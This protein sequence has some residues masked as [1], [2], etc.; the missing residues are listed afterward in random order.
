MPVATGPLLV[1]VAG[2]WCGERPTACAEL[3]FEMFEDRARRPSPVL[4]KW[5]VNRVDCRPYISDHGSPKSM[6]IRAPGPDLRLEGPFGAGTDA[7]GRLHSQNASFSFRCATAFGG[8]GRRCRS[9]EPKAAPEPPAAVG[10]SRRA[11]DQDRRRRK[12]TD[13]AFCQY[14]LTERTKFGEKW[15]AFRS[16]LSSHKA[17]HRKHRAAGHRSSSAGCE[18]LAPEGLERPGFGLPFDGRLWGVERKVWAAV[19]YRRRTQEY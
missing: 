8:R 19:L 4:T 1:I 13:D 15:N 10:R 17:V 5:R 16:R 9:F 7:T 6:R 11:T 3:H 12:C 18:V 14:I 2:P